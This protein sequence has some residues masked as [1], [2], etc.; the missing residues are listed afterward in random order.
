MLVSTCCQQ[1]P[2]DNSHGLNEGR[3]HGRSNLTRETA[4]GG[5]AL[6]F[7]GDRQTNDSSLRPGPSLETPEIGQTACLC[8]SLGLHFLPSPSQTDQR[9]PAGN[10]APPTLASLRTSASVTPVSRLPTI[11][12]PASDQFAQPSNGNHSHQ[13]DQ[14][15]LFLSIDS[16][17]RKMRGL[18]IDEV[19]LI[20]WMGEVEYDELGF[21]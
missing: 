12:S 17:S 4:A 20:E 21:G 9:E 6:S 15:P 10:M 19:G 7:L 14:G 5:G 13:P 8:F 3:P 11:V 1:G 2:C 18:V 16:G